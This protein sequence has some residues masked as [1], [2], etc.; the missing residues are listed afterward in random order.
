MIKITCEI[1]GKDMGARGNHE[2]DVCAH[3][4]SGRFSAKIR[5]HV[6]DIEYD[7]CYDCLTKLTDTIRQ[8]VEEM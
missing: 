7:V 5:F 8:I 1:C 4:K 2:V 3:S 6:N